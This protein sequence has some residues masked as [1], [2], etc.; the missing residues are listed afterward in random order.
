MQA[1]L[2]TLAFV[3]AAGLGAL[4]AAGCLIAI[5]FEVQGFGR[6]RD[7]DPRLGYLA[8]LALGLVVCVAAPFVVWRK[9]LR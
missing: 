2:R 9:L 5:L 8:L 4:F 3:A 7:T 6:A 1:T